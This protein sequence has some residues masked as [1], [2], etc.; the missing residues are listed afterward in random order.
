VASQFHIDAD[1]QVAQR[2]QIA[3]VSASLPKN[4]RRSL[5]DATGGTALS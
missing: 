4:N 1:P 3:M 5:S 2:A